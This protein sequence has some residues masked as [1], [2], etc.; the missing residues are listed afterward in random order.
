[1]KVKLLTIGQK[2]TEKHMRG[3]SHGTRMAM[4]ADIDAALLLAEARGAAAE[5]AETEAA[6]T[7][8][9]AVLEDCAAARIDPFSG[10]NARRFLNRAGRA[11]E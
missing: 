2:L 7:H 5:R 9:R 6:M 3:M 1:M 4:A 10:E 8:L 11:G